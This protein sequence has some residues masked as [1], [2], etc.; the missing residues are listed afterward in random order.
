[1]QFELQENQEL[2]IWSTVGSWFTSFV[3]LGIVL[4]K[5]SESASPS[6]SRILLSVPRKEFV[7]TAIAFG[8]S[9]HKLNSKEEILKEISLSSLSELAANSKVRLVLDFGHID[10]LFHEYYPEQ[11]KI[12]CTINGLHNTRFQL[13]SAVKRIY[14]LPSF[15]PEGNYL[16]SKLDYEALDKSSEREVWRTQ[17]APGVV[18]FG[19]LENFRLQSSAQLKNVLIAKITGR[20]IL[21]LEDAARLDSL[22]GHSKSSF[23]NCF[24]STSEF[25][26]L[27]VNGESILDLFDWV[28]LD[29]NNAINRLCASEN[30]FDRSVLSILELGVPRSQ[31]K[32]L[33]TFTSELNRYNSVDVTKLLGW[34]PPAG[35]NIW[36]WTK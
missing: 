34:N 5:L 31:G 19:D 24:A 10:V 17:G 11:K 26:K 20:E 33:D 13:A 15:Y 14:L 4:S 16:F 27:K 8:M 7:S 18:I 12:R 2:G 28:I 36:G 25:S 30:L 21:T 35:V 22:A 3:A 1:M 9:I 23:I 29:G 6:I 32:A